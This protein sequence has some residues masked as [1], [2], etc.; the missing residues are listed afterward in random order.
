MASIPRTGP[1]S[2]SRRSRPSRPRPATSRSSSTAARA[3][4]VEQ[5]KKAIENGVSK[6]NVNTDLQVVFA[7][8]TR[9]YIESGADQQGKGFDPRKLL[10]GGRDAIVDRT[11]ELMEEFGSVGKG[12]N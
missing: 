5:V 3:F 12:W 7:A 1:A 4:P 2:T 8:A 10:K 11:G 6:I 9:K